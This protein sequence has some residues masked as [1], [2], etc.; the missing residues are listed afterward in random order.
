LP[1]DSTSELAGLSPHSLVYLDTCPKNYVI[2][3]IFFWVMVGIL[4]FPTLWY[5]QK[6]VFGKMSTLAS[7]VDPQWMGYGGILQRPNRHGYTLKI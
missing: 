7:S 5:W 1:K 3:K 4:Q 6:Y 2:S